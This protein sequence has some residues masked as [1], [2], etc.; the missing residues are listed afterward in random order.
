MVGTQGRPSPAFRYGTWNLSSSELLALSCVEM[1]VAIELV[2]KT[3]DLPSNVSMDGA[4][5]PFE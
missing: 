3:S 1:Q 4:Q 2:A 5:E